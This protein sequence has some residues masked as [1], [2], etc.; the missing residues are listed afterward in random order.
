MRQLPP[1]FY[2]IGLPWICVVSLAGIPA[3]ETTQIQGRPIIRR[4]V[5]WYLY[6]TVFVDGHDV[7]H[8][9]FL[10]FYIR[11]F[12]DINLNVQ[13]LTS[14]SSVTRLPVVGV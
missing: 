12:R 9:R 10:V 3:N 1:Q 14:L 5:K 6:S 2:R 11:L 4:H 8:R 13:N 7:F